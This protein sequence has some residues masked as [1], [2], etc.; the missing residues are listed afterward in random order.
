MIAVSGDKFVDL[1]PRDYVEVGKTGVSTYQVFDIDA[2]SNRLT[3]RA[4]TEDGTLVD[5]LEI[6]KGRG[7]LGANNSVPHHIRPS[8]ETIYRKN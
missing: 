5:E 1:A 6:A 3:Y 7:A 2:R 4:W 8:G